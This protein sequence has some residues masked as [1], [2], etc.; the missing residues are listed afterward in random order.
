MD[1]RQRT[2]KIERLRIAEAGSGEYDDEPRRH[3]LLRLFGW[4]LLT[5]ALTAIGAAAGWFFWLRHEAPPPKQTAA[6]Q[7]TPPPPPVVELET[8]ES[9]PFQIRFDHPETWRVAEGDSQVIAT[10]PPLALRPAG[11]SQPKQGQ[12]VL[13]IER[14]RDTIPG[15]A[16]GPA[17]A[18]RESTRIEYAK[19]S[20]DQ[21]GATYISFL[22][23][24]ESKDEGIDAVYVSGDSGYVLNQAV[25]QADIIRADPLISFSFR[26]CENKQCTGKKQPLTLDPTAWENQQFAKPLEDML[27]SIVVQ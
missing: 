18:V 12:V 16:G 23:Y 11:S 21:R 25:D 26:S 4:L 7:Q 27:R 2:H 8:Y 6:T 15:F 3:W 9:T 10:S 17:I 5:A 19:P 13:T 20:P 24:S 1:E 22:G 14:K